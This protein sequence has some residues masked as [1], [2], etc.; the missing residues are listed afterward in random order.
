MKEA[1]IFYSW[2]SD[3][4]NST[5][6]TFI[7]DALEK[8]VKII[9]ADDSIEINPVVDRDTKDE[10][11]S[12]DIVHSIFQKIEQSA[13]FVCDV[14]IINDESANRPTPNPNVLV[15]LGYAMK[16]LGQGRVLLVM[17]TAYGEIKKLPF[18][19]DHRRV[20]SYSV[21][22]SELSTTKENENGK[23][24]NAK[25]IEKRILAKKFESNLKTILEHHSSNTIETSK[26][27][28][29]LLEESFAN[30]INEFQVKKIALNEIKKLCVEINNLPILT[31]KS[32]LNSDE[33]SQ[34]M[35]DCES[36]SLDSLSLFSFGC[37]EGDKTYSKV[38]AESL[39]HLTDC[40][41]PERTLDSIKLYPAL[42]HFYA[43][44]IASVASE[45]YENLTSLIHQTKIRD[46]RGKAESP[47]K[48]LVPYSVIKEDEAKRLPNIGRYHTP[49]NQ[50]IFIVLREPL[51]TVIV[52]DQAYKEA[53]YRFEYLFALASAIEAQKFWGDDNY[54]VPVGSYVWE[55]YLQ[56]MHST[57]AKFVTTQTDFEIEQLGEKWQ[58]FQ[59]GMFGSSL[60]T[61]IEIKK[62]ADEHLIKVV[63]QY[64]HSF[65]PR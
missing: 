32:Y 6:R 59:S 37:S 35:L 24:E 52:N 26:T 2:Q 57:G 56:N 14:T 65:N 54:Y 31:K 5:N 4:Q 58:P 41:A 39:T 25:S 30:S 61:F 62:K 42:L 1:K 47:A 51:R 19:L 45:K 33:L 8:A 18:D 46:Y 27:S 49:L 28:I 3:R 21:H 15:E 63:Q 9:R 13:I 11:G 50:H 40:I 60:K 16:A 44:G 38:W 43:S 7:Q 36:L 55:S 48:S 12:P 53:F 22:D 64:F 29:E 20:I 23:E 10:P 17:N 34:F